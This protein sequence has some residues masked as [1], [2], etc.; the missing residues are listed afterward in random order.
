MIWAQEHKSF[1]T[2]SGRKVLMMYPSLFL[3]VSVEQTKIQTDRRTIIVLF[4]YI[5]QYLRT[6]VAYSFGISL[7]S[8]NGIE[9]HKVERCLKQKI[10]VFVDD[11][12]TATYACYI[13]IL[14]E[15]V[16]FSHR[17]IFVDRTLSSARCSWYW[18]SF[19]IFGVKIHTTVGFGLHSLRVFTKI[20]R[21]VSL[22]SVSLTIWLW[23]L[24]LLVLLLNMLLQPIK[25]NRKSCTW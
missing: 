5:K 21:L 7:L 6:K 10:K 17:C 4:F 23:K 2:P 12:H 8:R 16:W 9:K 25:I 24:R 19:L 18:K 20:I 14:N 3:M 1:A 22:S 11:H 15:S 13:I